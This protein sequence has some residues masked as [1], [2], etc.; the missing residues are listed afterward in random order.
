MNT[1]IKNLE[2][3]IHN[4]VY[5]IEDESKFN[6]RK[7]VDDMSGIYCYTCKLVIKDKNYY[8]I[9]NGDNINI[10]F[11]IGDF[12]YSFNIKNYYT[13]FNGDF[14]IEINE[15]K[16]EF[17]INFNLGVID[18]EYYKIIKDNNYAVPMKKC[19]DFFNKKWY[20]KLKEFD[21]YYIKNKITGD[22]GYQRIDNIYEFV[23]ENY[24]DYWIENNILKVIVK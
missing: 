10:K 21:V 6:Y 16:G 8:D 19:S 2:I 18:L 3:E 22:F 13:N 9:L 11:I 17:D 1:E 23:K 14:D 12:K 5:K 7:I 4:R 15:Y 24:E 20:Q